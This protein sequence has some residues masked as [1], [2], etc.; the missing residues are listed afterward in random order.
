M[1]NVVAGVYSFGFRLCIPSTRAWPSVSPSSKPRSRSASPN[2]AERDDFVTSNMH[3]EH[4]Q[5]VDDQKASESTKKCSAQ[6]AH[7]TENVKRKVQ[8]SPPPLEMVVGSAAKNTV[9]GVRRCA[10]QSKAESAPRTTI[11]AMR[12]LVYN[13]KQSKPCTVKN[14]SFPSTW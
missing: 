11:Q 3:K 6:K 5:I 13:V 1:T 7:G 14:Y 9:Q 12:D 8:L 10:A 2:M 4:Q